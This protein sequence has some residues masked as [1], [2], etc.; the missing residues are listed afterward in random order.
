MVLTTNAYGQKS[1]F[2]SFTKYAQQQG[3]SS[4]NIKKIFKDHRGFLWVATQDGINKFD[5]NSF[6]KYTHNSEAKHQIN[7]AD[8]REIIEDSVH[9]KLWIIPTQGNINS[10]SLLTGNVIDNIVIPYNDPEGWS[11]TMLL[12]KQKIWIGTFT[13]VKIYDISTGKFEEDIKPPVNNTKNS[14]SFEVGK[15]FE[16]SHNNI[17]V[18]Y[19]GYGI[20]VYKADSKKIIKEITLTDLNDILKTGNFRFN[21]FL[22]NSPNEILLATSQGLR[23][24]KFDENYNCTVINNPCDGFDKIN[25]ESVEAIGRTKNKVVLVSAQSNLYAF[26]NNSFKIHYYKGNYKRF[27][28]KLVE[29]RSLYIYRLYRQYCMARFRAGSQ[30]F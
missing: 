18:F 8:I 3:L 28:G 19:C 7:G 10:I 29:F 24:I 30:F 27:R 4:Y 2:K 14:T 12:Q 11:L 25:T 16:D 21:D 9:E 5:G 15:M 20:V 17:W 6:I 26:D 22:F 13:G 1:E 23:K